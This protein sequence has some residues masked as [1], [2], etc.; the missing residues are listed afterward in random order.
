MITE[1]TKSE[2]LSLIRK[3][4][5]QIAERQL[6]EDIAQVGNIMHF[7]AGE[8]IMDFGAYVKL[9]PLIIEGSIKVSREDEEGNELFLYYLQP[10]E[11]CSM[12]F[13]CCLMDKKSE[14]RTVAEENTTLI[15]IPTRYMDEWMSRYP[16]WKNFVMTSY[17]RRMLELV[18]TIDSIAFKKMDERLLD[19]L[20]K[21]AEANNNRTLQAT[22]Q[23]IAYDLNASRE[24][25]SRLLKQLEK[26]GL[27]ELGRNRIQ[28]L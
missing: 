17:D 7:K 23:E 19:Y 8:L 15:G 25:V 3:N 11:T 27:V 28:L 1:N 13:T 24:A 10:G 9:V 14:I 16:S 5:P 2:I 20:E 6:Q 21:K 12:S 4:Y 26:D 22:H 18:Y